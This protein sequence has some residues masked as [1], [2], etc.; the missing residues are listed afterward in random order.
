M[1]QM[2]QRMLE[3]K[4]TLQK[5]LVSA[6]YALHTLTPTPLTLV[7]LRLLAPW[8]VPLVDCRGLYEK[9]GVGWWERGPK[10]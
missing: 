4:K 3:L 2:Q 10:A 7:L 9:S 8:G 5:E 1:K 6:P